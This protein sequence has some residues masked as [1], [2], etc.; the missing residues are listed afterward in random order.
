ML[1]CPSGVSTSWRGLQRM[2]QF[3]QDAAIPRELGRSSWLSPPGH[4][5]AQEGEG[6]ECPVLSTRE[7]QCPD[8]AGL[9]CQLCLSE[10]TAVR[11]WGAY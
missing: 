5:H 1:F 2:Q 8:G 11:G 10:A 9:R 6:V 4:S 7:K 3:P